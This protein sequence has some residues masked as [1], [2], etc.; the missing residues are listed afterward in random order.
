MLKKRIK[1]ATTGRSGTARNGPAKG[2]VTSLSLDPPGIVIRNGSRHD[3]DAGLMPEMARSPGRSAK[4][5]KAE[6]SGMISSGNW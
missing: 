4:I 1:D 2:S 5:L 6:T 3:A